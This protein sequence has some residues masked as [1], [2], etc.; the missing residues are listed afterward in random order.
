LLSSI[1]SG[2]VAS[3][4]LISSTVGGLAGI[5]MQRES[6][7]VMP[8]GSKQTWLTATSTVSVQLKART[9]GHKTVTNTLVQGFSP[10]DALTATATN[11]SVFDAATANGGANAEY[12]IIKPYV[13]ATRA[14]RHENE[15]T[16]VS[17]PDI[18]SNAYSHSTHTA[19]VSCS[20]TCA[21]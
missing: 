10:F 14:W 21:K 5:F 11:H 7:N 3:T 12:H 20:C 2:K 15:I 16:S 6:T 8:D 1:N 18:V 19:Q 17:N 13:L 9:D 4:S